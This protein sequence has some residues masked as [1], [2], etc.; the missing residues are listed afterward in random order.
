MHVNKGKTLAQCLSDR[1]DYGKNPDKTKESELISAYA[2]D[3]RTADAEFLLSKRQYQAITGRNKNYDGDKRK[4]VIAYQIWQSF[5][6]GEVTPEEANKIHLP[7]PQYK[8]L[9]AGK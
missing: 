4:D 7:D 6:P 8:C 2:C 5:K 9:Q 3:P 1:I